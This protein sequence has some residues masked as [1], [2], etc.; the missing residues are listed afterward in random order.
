MSQSILDVV[1]TCF[2][3]GFWLD[4]LLESVAR[5]VNFRHNVVIVD[6]AS[7][8]RLTQLDLSSLRPA[9][10]LQNLEILR[11]D[12]NF[13]GA[14]RP[15]NIG[16]AAGNSEYVLFLDADDL[17]VDQSLHSSIW[18]MSNLNCDVSIGSWATVR[19]ASLKA[20]DVFTPTIP[21]SPSSGW[22][23]R[24]WE[25]NLSI[26]I[27]SAVFRRT[28]LNFGPYPFSENYRTK[29]DFYFW[30]SFFDQK[31]KVHRNKC[32]QA[33]Y[34]LSQSSMSQGNFF[35]NGVLFCEVAA[36]LAQKFPH[37]KHHLPDALEYA[38]QFY[39]ERIDPSYQKLFEVSIDRLMIGEI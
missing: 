14:S 11:L 37:L 39:G 21:Y 38:R 8:D 13:G 7:P 25:R 27:H 18:E 29:E 28:S 17:L 16:F 15:R 26:P 31:I 32:V 35:K 3:Q 33:V 30:T 19:T 1:V 6:D 24:N 23:F 12:S 20:G 2:R 9:T 36:A 4:S 10:K 5:A 34:R 22:V